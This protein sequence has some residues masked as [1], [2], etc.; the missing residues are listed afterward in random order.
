[1]TIFFIILTVV[2]W[3]VA[4]I[5]DKTALKSGD[6]YI[7]TI[8]RGIVIGITVILI[9]LIGGKAKELMALPAKTIIL[10]GVSGLFAG[11][12]GTFTFYKALQTGATS[13]IV[14][15]AA[16]YPLV[17]ALLSVLILGETV[18]AARIAGTVLIVGGIW[19]VK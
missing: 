19:L 6:P 17:T 15:L 14:P 9:M 1:M 7:G 12:L 2:F 3:G 18:T 16:T 10:F 11:L 4:P 13:M 5:L 8:I